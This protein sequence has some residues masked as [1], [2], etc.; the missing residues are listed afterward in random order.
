MTSF[1]I[2]FIHAGMGWTVLFQ[3]NISPQ[4]EVNCHLHV[5]QHPEISPCY[6][7]QSPASTNSFYLDCLTHIYTTA[8]LY[9]YNANYNWSFSLSSHCHLCMLTSCI[10][11]SMLGPFLSYNR[12]HWYHHTICCS[13]EERSS[14]PRAQLVVAWTFYTLL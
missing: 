6:F 14:L 3:C 12:T 13:F 2:N 11:W 7:L 1:Y 10:Q 4:V 9:M 5:V 8:I